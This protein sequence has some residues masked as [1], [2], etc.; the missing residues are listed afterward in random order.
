M[1][2][3]DIKVNHEPKNYVKPGNRFDQGNAKKLVQKK[4]NNKNRSKKFAKATRPKTKT[5]RSRVQENVNMDEAA[6]VTMVML[7]AVANDKV[8]W[9]KV[10]K[11]KTKQQS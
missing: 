5:T 7:G 3:F 8:A 6:P 10:E 2:D 1:I 11:S 9:Q 4:I